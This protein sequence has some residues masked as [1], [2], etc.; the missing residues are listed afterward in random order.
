MNKISNRKKEHL[1]VCI[2]EN[3]VFTTKT[4][5]FANYDFVHCAITEVDIT[6]IKLSSFF[7][8]HKINL[9]FLISCMTGGTIEADNINARLAEAAN[10]LQIPI[11]V[12]SQREMLENTSNLSSYKIIRNNAQ[13]VPVLSNLG[14]A[15]VLHLKD[16]FSIGKLIDIVEAAAFVIHLNP[17]QELF[18]QEGQSNFYGLLHSIEKIVKNISVP[19][20]IKEVGS[21]I[22]KECAK[23]LL[24]VGVS[25]I[26][27][28]GAG[29]TSWSAVEILRNGESKENYFWNWGLP[30]S[31]CVRT[32]S[33]LKC[34]YDFT[35]ISSGG[36]TNGIDIAKSIALGAD[37]TAAARIVLTKLVTENAESVID[38]INKW[39]ADVKRVMY[40]TGSSTLDSLRENK[41]I[42]KEELK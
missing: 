31:Y 2:N 26:D 42:I 30:T 32:V 20:I 27:V 16:I 23:K 28:A 38:M 9:P 41:I 10:Y 37:L 8:K 1:D 36:I 18:Q 21:G 15:Q 34:N 11:G 14:A 25:G 12:G 3:P 29:G 7:F 5:G 22:D 13:N 17:L 19:V 33:E 6:K 40:L 39:F 35:L 24:N 4:N